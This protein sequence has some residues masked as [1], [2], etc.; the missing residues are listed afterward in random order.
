MR[1]DAVPYFKSD[2][3]DKNT[4]PTTS[5]EIVDYGNA[6]Q[7]R[8]C[9]L[10][11]LN[12]LDQSNPNVR[13][14]IVE[15]LNR[16]SSY[17][18]AGF[19]FDASKH[20]DPVD[21]K[22][23]V[24]SLDNLPTAHGF[25]NGTKPFIFQEVIDLGGEAI[26]S[27]DYTGH[28]RVTE[29]KYGKYL[30]D[31]FRKLG[32]QQLSYL[33]NFGEGWAMLKSGDALAFVDNHDNQ[34]GHGAGGENILTFRASRLY[35]QAVAF[36]L[37]L[38]YGVTRVMSSYYWP[39]NMVNGKDKNDWIGPPHEADFSIK[40]V[41]INP[42]FTCGNGWICEHRWREIYQMVA[43]R[44]IVQGTS[45]NDWWDNGRNQ[46]AFCRG[47]KGFIAINNEAWDLFQNLQTCLPPGLYCD[48]ISGGLAN[49]KCVGKTIVVG[50]L[51][52]AQIHI[53]SFDDSPIVAIHVDS[54][55]PSIFG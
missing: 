42:D 39:Q 5:G 47:G 35:K 10:S 14:K 22:A 36:M 17:G 40:D 43:F 48:I 9:K 31:V 19:R 20:M 25:A 15:F 26:T 38:P 46:I 23:I 32:G 3:H 41:L 2:F 12:D 16:L 11:G 33:R 30:G 50:L 54:K 6:Q 37:A 53:S 18:V 21:L 1:Y 49:G 34:R 28:G 13:A 52:R 4:C 51:G 29:F 8:N 7:V 45:M 55:V 27:N 44:N 24:D